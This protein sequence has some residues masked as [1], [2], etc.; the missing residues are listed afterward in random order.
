VVDLRQPDLY[1]NRELSLLE[2][3]RRVLDQ[4]RDDSVP[5]LERLK[6][7]CIVSSNLDEFF[8]IRVAGLKQQV[9]LGAA[10]IG[11]DR[12]GPSEQ[13][14]R[15]AETTR[16]L[17][18]DQYA[19]LNDALIPALA[20]H[21]MRFLK[22]S[23]WS[24]RQERWVKRHFNRELLPVLSPI[25]LDPAHPFPRILNKSLNFIVDLEGKDAFGRNSGIAIVQA[26]RS[27]PRLIRI[28]ESHSEGS[29]DFVFLSSII[30]AHVGDLFPGMRPQGCFQFRVT[31]NSDLL[32]DDEEV[33]DLLHALEGELP[34]RR[35][36]DA[37]R[38]EVAD[39]CPVEMTTFLSQQFKLG[40][41]DVYR[42]N[43]PVNLMRL[44][45][46]GDLVDRPD[47]KYPGFAPGQPP[48]LTRNTDLF[49][50]IRKG[51]VLLHH[52]FQSFA[53]VVD[54]VRQAAADPDVL[55]LK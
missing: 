52:P 50:T 34:A 51:D 31:R 32:V 44:M 3:N 53:P 54:F 49:D 17:I 29:H 23:E 28:P 39:D 20:A 40:P 42:C 4:A 41:E 25:G 30:H 15:I 1:F 46:I 26:P 6:F 45:A 5:L 7:V 27:L 2:F 38:L 55:T 43:G 9:A 8:E 48:R 18:R 24:A 13:L 47:L 16:A 36:S 33:D 22:R 14:K 37:V 35:F 12:L 19:V 11:P 21:G 10:P